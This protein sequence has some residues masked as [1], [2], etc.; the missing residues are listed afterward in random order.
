[1]TMYL[2]ILSG[3]PRAADFGETVDPLTGAGM[4]GDRPWNADRIRTEAVRDC[5]VFPSR[6]RC[7]FDAALRI[8]RDLT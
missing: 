4:T 3:I 5:D 1:M 2:P 6:A 7:I 8:G